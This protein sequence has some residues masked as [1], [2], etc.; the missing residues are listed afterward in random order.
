VNCAEEKGSVDS[1]LQSRDSERGH[2]CPDDHPIH[3]S[4][5]KQSHFSKRGENPELRG[6]KSVGPYAPWR[7]LPDTKNKIPETTH[8]PLSDHAA[9]VFGLDPTPYQP[10]RGERETGRH[11]TLMSLVPEGQ[12]V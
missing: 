6:V 1:F 5:F 4:P 10:F 7:I 3:A 11:G 8:L 9:S 12:A 2:A